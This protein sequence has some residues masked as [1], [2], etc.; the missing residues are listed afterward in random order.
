MPEEYIIGFKRAHLAFLHQIVY[1]PIQRKQVPLNPLS[2]DV[3]HE[4]LKFS[5]EYVIEIE[6]EKK[7][8]ISLIR[9]DHTSMAFQHAIGNLNVKTKCLVDHFDPDKWKVRR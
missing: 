3:D 9:C 1:D 8:R 4:H 2:D 7:K 6:L 5:G